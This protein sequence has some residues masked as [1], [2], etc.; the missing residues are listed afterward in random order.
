MTLAKRSVD[1]VTSG[2]HIVRLTRL[3]FGS[4]D[5]GDSLPTWLEHSISAMLSRYGRFRTV[6]GFQPLMAELRGAVGKPLEIFVV[7]EGK[8]GKSTLLNALLGAELS[9]VHFLPA[10]RCFLRYVPC[11]Q[12]RD[13]C[14][15]YVRAVGTIHDWLIGRLP[16]AEHSSELFDTRKYVVPTSLAE[17]LLKEE[18]ARCKGAGYSAAIVEVERE[19]PLAA[20]TSLPIGTRIVDTQGLNQIFSWEAGASAIDV[21]GH[22]T[23]ERLMQ[24]LHSSP[25]GKHLDWQL[26]R[27]NILLWVVNAKRYNSAATLAALR[28]FSKYGKPVVLAVTHVDQFDEGDRKRILE[29]VRREYDSLVSAICPVDGKRGLSAALECDHGALAATGVSAVAAE[30]QRLAGDDSAFVRATGT[31]I[32]LRETES[33]QRIALARFRNDIERERVH[34]GNDREEIERHRRF[35]HEHIGLAID[36][37]ERDAKN[38]ISD[39]ARKIDRSWREVMIRDALD[40][41]GRGRVIDSKVRSAEDDMFASLRATADRLKREGY[42]LPA[43]DAEGSRSADAVTANYTLSIKEAQVSSPTLTL[44]ISPHLFRALD[45]FFGNLFGIFSESARLESE[46]QLE[47]FRQQVRSDACDTINQYCA[48]W[49]AALRVSIDVA[50]DSATEALEGVRQ[51]LEAVEGRSLETTCQA[52]DEA[53]SGLAAPAAVPSVMLASVRGR[54]AMLPSHD[55]N[56]L[57]Q[58]LRRR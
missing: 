47:A 28:H 45:A 17:E 40:I 41:A 31:Y 35:A 49:R 38:A 10:T 55:K 21:D 48:A 14:G 30:V 56:P 52:I 25:R 58:P 54:K 44:Q 32:S 29:G 1:E 7:G 9:A 39:I 27:C 15:M 4:A 6:A 33:Q 57:N 19:V 13:E 26:R 5:S 24:W 50:H 37:G 16:V 46:R 11:E 12:P 53:L 22:S 3:I 42:R 51:V 43:F 18:A 8:F 23:P 20:G 2:L 36:Q 34:L